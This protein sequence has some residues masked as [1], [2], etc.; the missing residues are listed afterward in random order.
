MGIF[1]SVAG[2]AR[3]TTVEQAGVLC[4]L[5]FIFAGYYKAAEFLRPVP[6]DLTL[7]FAAGTV[8][9]SAL[10]LWRQRR[11]PAGLLPLVALFAVMAIG[12]HRPEGWGSYATQ[13]ELRLFSLTAVAA[14]APLL[15]LRDSDQRRLFVVATAVLGLV[16]AVVAL[17]ASVEAGTYKRTGIFNASPIHLARGSGFACLMLCLLF[18]QRRLRLPVFAPALV[19]ALS[20]LVLSGTRGPLVALLAIGIVTAAL[21]LAGG[22]DRTRVWGTLVAA[23]GLLVCGIAF[24][25]IADTYTGRHL[26]ELLSGS[27]GNTGSVRWALWRETVMLIAENPLGIGWGH[28][29]E[30][31]QVTHNEIAQQHSHNILLEITLEAGW[32]AGALFA[33]LTAVVLLRLFRQTGAPGTATEGRW[34]SDALVAFV[35]LAYWLACAA[36]SG[37]V[38]DNRPFW[39]MLGMALATLGSSPTA[40][41]D[42]V[43]GRSKRSDTARHGSAG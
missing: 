42:S 9:F 40:P 3:G 2:R 27:L 19:I 36:F 8:A 6:I 34:N 41:F 31:I 12:L 29:A 7:L 35:V 4:F 28:M 16:M 25:Y 22:A 11:L 38:N 1:E 37:D 18:W 33:T 14:F 13:K 21:C 20:G 23:C 17:A 24:L 32:P 39:A 43:D 10:A 15:L 30:F 5:L 26:V